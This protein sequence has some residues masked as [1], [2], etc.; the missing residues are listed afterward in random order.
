MKARRSLTHGTSLSMGRTNTTSKMIRKDLRTAL[1][2]QQGNNTGL[3]ADEV[4]GKPVITGVIP[5]TEAARSGIGPGMIVTSIDGKPV[6]EKIDE[7]GSNFEVTLTRQPLSQEPVLPRD[8]CR[9]ATHT[10]HS[11]NSRW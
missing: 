9:Q 2:N 10:L 7:V 8:C 4:E 1:R 3:R 6:A 5:D 11:I